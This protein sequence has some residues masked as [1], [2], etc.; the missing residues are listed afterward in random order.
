MRG[1][2]TRAFMIVFVFFLS[3]Q[4]PMFTEYLANIPT[5]LE[6]R[7]VIAQSDTLATM[8]RGNCVDDNGDCDY[9]NIAN[10]E[11]DLNGDGDWTNDDTDGDGTWDY[12]DNDDDGD[13][14]PTWFECPDGRNTTHNFCVGVGQTYD[15]LHDQL[16]N[17]DQ[18]LLQVA[19]PN[20]KMDV[21]AYFWTND[22][23]LLLEDDIDGYSSGVARSAEDGKL[24]WV[25][26]TRQNGAGHQRVYTW[27]PSDGTTPTS[28][29]D[30]NSSTTTSRSAFDENG[31]LYTEANNNIYQIRTSDGH[32][33]TKQSG[34]GATG[35]GGDIMAH[36]E[37]GTWYFVDAT[38]GRLYTGN[39]D[40][41]TASR[42]VEDS[43]DNMYSNRRYVGATILSNST[44]LANDGTS[45]YMYTGDW[46]NDSSGVETVLYTGTD[47]SGDMATCTTPFTDTD[48]DGLEDFLEEN[49]YSTN[50]SDTDSDDDDLNDYQEILNGT[51]P[52][53]ADSDD[54]G[55]FDGHEVLVGSNPNSVEDSDGDGTPDWWDSDEDD[56]GIPGTLECNPTNPDAYNLVNGGFEQPVISDDSTSQRAESSVPGWETTDSSNTIE[57]WNGNAVSGHGPGSAHEGD[58]YAEINSQST[59]ALYQDFSSTAGDIMVWTYFHAKRTGTEDQ[60]QLKIDDS[61]TALSSMRIIDYSNNSNQAWANNTGSY[62]V[63]DGQSETR[64]A[65]EAITGTGSGNLVDS[66]NFRPVCTLDSDGDG[67]NNNLDN[68]SDGDGVE[69]PTNQRRIGTETASP[70]SWTRIRT[71]TVLPMVMTLTLSLV[72]RTSP[73]T[74]PSSMGLTITS[75][76]RTM[77]C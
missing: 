58:Q 41:T 31:N 60:M 50:P 42:T 73:S 14:W 68:D 56:D 57:I 30:T 21:Y 20:D 24:W 70:D 45:L 12:Q 25:D 59:A 46:E 49:V 11:E 27:D 38:T 3:T 64:F 4:V 71:G 72:G 54:D 9:D 5:E 37:N 55:L 34:F 44:L 47:A 39:S 53:D 36:P 76:S 48:G 2:M 7:P 1:K 32:Q 75:N 51:D 19:A 28:I 22:T 26:S 6:R 67:I 10:A 15:Y 17:C 65:F 33:T 35:S 23:M 29:G 40:F 18:P 66:I 62:L 52:N 74:P 61:S 63:P 13:G 77:I 8:T 43:L 69:V 16:F